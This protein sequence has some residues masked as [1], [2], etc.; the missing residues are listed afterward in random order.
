MENTQYNTDYQ[1]E[2]KDLSNSTFVV[3]TLQELRTKLD[4]LLENIKKQTKKSL[5]INHLEIL[6]LEI[7]KKN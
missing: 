6:N 4:S 1:V 5:E 3:R 7:I 2:D